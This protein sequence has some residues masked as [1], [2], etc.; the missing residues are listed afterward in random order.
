MTV[1][2]HFELTTTDG[3]ARPGF[4]AEGRDL[5]NI[6][7]NAKGSNLLTWAVGG[8]FKISESAQVG[9][10]FELPLFGN[11]DLF[12]YRFTVDFILRF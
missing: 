11:R 6:G 5:A 2:N 10:A 1:P 3:Q 9:A 8:R 12:R 7:T 4:G